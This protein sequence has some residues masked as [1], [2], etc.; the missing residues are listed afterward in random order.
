MVRLCI[1]MVLFS[2]MAAFVSGIMIVVANLLI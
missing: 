1:D 2:S